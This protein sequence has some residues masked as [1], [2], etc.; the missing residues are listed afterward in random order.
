MRLN[1]PLSATARPFQSQA[2]LPLVLVDNMP[3]DYPARNGLARGS[4]STTGS[5]VGSARLSHHYTSDEESVSSDNAI[6]EK[7]LCRRLVAEG[8]K[9]TRVVVTLMGLLP[10]GAMEEKG[11]VL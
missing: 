2:A 8:I 11:W 5:P 1:S 10:P 6:S 3:Q 4:V 7:S 9:V